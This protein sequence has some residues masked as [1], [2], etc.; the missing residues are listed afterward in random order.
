MPPEPGPLEPLGGHSPE[1]FF[2]QPPL[3][4]TDKHDVAFVRE[5]IPSWYVMGDLH[6]LEEHK[7]RLIGAVGDIAWRAL[8]LPTEE[9]AGHIW[10][11]LQRVREIHALEHGEMEPGEA[12]EFA[13]HLQKWTEESVQ[14]LEI[15]RDHGLWDAIW[16]SEPSISSTLAARDSMP[17]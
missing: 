3:S 11:T 6:V 12:E 4:E 17:P 9:R 13:D 15:G 8:R 2:L 16:G 5:D 7:D 14:M 1:G 10:L